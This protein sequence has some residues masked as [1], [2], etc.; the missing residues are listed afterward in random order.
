VDSKISEIFEDR[1]LVET[2]RV[3]LPRLFTIAELE[4]SRA[5]KTGMEAMK[6]G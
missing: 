6:Y 1:N 2:I 4:S 3:K 5:G